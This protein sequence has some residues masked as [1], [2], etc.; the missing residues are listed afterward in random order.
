MSVSKELLKKLCGDY[1]N[2]FEKHEIELILDIESEL[3]KD[4]TMPSSAHLE[5][6]ELRL[7]GNKTKNS[8]GEFKYERKFYP[9]INTLISD[10]LKGKSSILKCIKFALTGRDKLKKDV[11]SW[12]EHILLEFKIGDVTYT[13]YIDNSENRIKAKLYR[14]NIAQFDGGKI[15]DVDC[16]FDVSSSKDLESNCEIFFYKQL[17]ITS[18]KWTQKDSQKEVNKLNEASTS[19]STFFKTIYLESKDSGTLVFGAQ[20]D[21]LFQILLGLGFTSSMNRLKIRK[22][23]LQF[24]LSKIVD[25]DG[26]ANTNNE[27]L[28][29]KL[30]EEIGLAKKE[31][32]INRGFSADRNVGE[33]MKEKSSLVQQIQYIENDR[34]LSIK[35]Y[36]ESEKK[37]S[38]LMTKKRHVDEDIRKLKIQNDKIQKD[39]LRIEEHID[40]GSFFSNLEIKSCPS[41]NNHLEFIKSSVKDSHSCGLCHHEIVDSE[42]QEDVSR[43]EL[44]K[45]S[46][47][48]EFLKINEQ[49]RVLDSADIRI[50]TS[51]E[52]AENSVEHVDSTNFDDEV[53]SLMSLVSVLDGNIEKERVTIDKSIK[54]FREAEDNL[55]VLNYRLNE[56]EILAVDLAENFKSSKQTHT[57]SLLESTITYL[58]EYRA[59]ANTSILKEFKVIILTVL[60]SLG[61]ESF[62][63]IEIDSKLRIK[64][65]QGGDKLSYSDITEGEQL[66]VKVALYLALV[67]LNSEHGVGNHPRFLI[68]DSPGKEEADDKYFDGLIEA[69]NTVE[70]EFSDKIQILIGSA[71]RRLSDI[72]PAAKQEIKNKQEVFF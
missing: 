42:R 10:N 28:I 53:T 17:G 8:E 35:R 31:I 56:A 12:I 48:Q 64:Y 69:F 14:T 50:S 5:L 2:I 49:L 27:K 57:I 60:H 16:I 58:E 52:E 34:L 70:R 9:G 46:L 18:L 62:T 40:I 55:A 15:R 30:Q 68:I 1:K 72:V 11:S 67:K 3:K 6:C 4:I 19:W 71:D 36:S 7:I 32:G 25:V 23:K 66:R 24:E 45:H 44:R 37:I 39:I 21:L 33:M 13:S 54:S 38:K 26:S 47:E 41:C 51:L 29:L 22:E 59:V 63:D 20:G 61:L 43:L 65:L